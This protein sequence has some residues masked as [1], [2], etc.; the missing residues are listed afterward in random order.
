MLRAF[1]AAVSSKV[2]Q[3]LFTLANRLVLGEIAG[4]V[5]LKHVYEIAQVK[6]QDKALHGVPLKASSGVAFRSV[7][8][9]RWG[10]LASSEKLLMLQLGT[11]AYPSVI[12]H[13]MNLVGRCQV[14]CCTRNLADFHPVPA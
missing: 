2:G 6:A 4:K 3:H 8:S 12:T 5:S 1:D 13:F 10:G 9:Q 14:G 7:T 11:L